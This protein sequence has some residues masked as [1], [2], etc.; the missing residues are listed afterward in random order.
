MPKIGNNLSSQ[1]IEIQNE[2]F[3]VD[4]GEGTQVGLRKNK[5][6]FSRIKH[7]FISHLHGD[8]YFGLIGLISTFS[9]LNRS[10]DLHVYGPLGIKELII[11]QIKA[12]GSW[13]K[14]KLIFHELSSNNS[15]LIFQSD[16]IKVSTIPLSHR[17][18]TN[19]FLF[20][21][22]NLPLTLNREA[23]DKN[24]VSIAYSN[25]LKQGFDVVNERGIV[26]KNSVL[27][28]AGKVAKSYAYCSD[29]EYDESIVKLIN[30][31]DA[32]YHESTFLEKHVKLSI[33][34][35]HSTAKQAGKIAK[36]S[37]TKLLIL[38]HYS[39]RYE[40]IEMFKIEA[41]TEF[42]NVVLAEDSKIIEI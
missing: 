11:N 24:D 26:I 32:L 7:I 28:L 22:V 19:G 1:I 33:T 2:I 9:L 18:Y 10:A 39:S 36:L 23:I 8:H 29:T 30:N 27:T 6:K 13:T 42:E 4:C 14:Y 16:F 35:K 37:N 25:K 38:G 20:N 3:L 34:T 41:K 5:I 31:C 17:I 40:N 15:Q 12:S 21:E